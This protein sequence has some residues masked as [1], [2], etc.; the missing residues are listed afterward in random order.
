MTIQRLQGAE[1][2][3]EYRK[4]AEGYPDPTAYKAIQNVYK[5]DERFQKLLH[6]IFDIC[7]LAGFR[8]QG[9]IVLEDKKTGRIWR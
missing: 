2:M 4:N 5:E 6:S 1:R 3:N 7:D 8:I 9:R